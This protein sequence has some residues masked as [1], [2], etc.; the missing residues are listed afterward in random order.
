MEPLTSAIIAAVSAGATFRTEEYAQLKSLIEK[1]FGVE[2]NVVKAVEALE[3]NPNSIELKAALE[4]EILRAEID[5]NSVFE[6]VLEQFLK[7]IK[8]KAGGSQITQTIVGGASIQVS[9]AGNSVTIIRPRL[10]GDSSTDAPPPPKK[11][12]KK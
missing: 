8:S 5:E 2:S 10:E 12:R 11:K 4:A 1:S 6:R 9:G 7:A 3:A